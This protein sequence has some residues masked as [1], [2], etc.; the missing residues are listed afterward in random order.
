MSRYLALMINPLR[1]IRLALAV[2]MS[3]GCVAAMNTSRAAQWYTEPSLTLSAGRDDNFLRTANGDVGQNIYSATARLTAGS[4]TENSNVRASAYATPYNYPGRD[5][6][7]N[8][9]AGANATLSHDY[10]RFGLNLDGGIARSVLLAYENV[11]VDASRFVDDTT[12]RA[13]SATPTLR[14]SITPTFELRAAASHS[15]VEYS[16]S[17]ASLY[18]DYRINAPSLTATYLFNETTQFSVVVSDSLTEY[19]NTAFPATSET[20]SGRIGVNTQ[21]SERFDLNVSVGLRRTTS[22]TTQLQPVCAVFVGSVCIVFVNQPVENTVLN[23]GSTYNASLTWQ[24]VNGSITGR[25]SQEVVP[26]GQAASLLG[27][28][29]G[30]TITHGISPY[31]SAQLSVTSSRYRADANTA[32]LNSNVNYDF[33][34]VE[35]AL[36]WRVSETWTSRLTYGRTRYD[37]VTSADKTIDNS[38]YLTLSWNPLRRY[39]SF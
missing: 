23:E 13:V 4:Q 17:R 24:Y 26:S 20:Q 35:P 21:M 10:E 31:L 6:L 34:R 30:G 15:D 9:G 16:G 8:T 39:V 11:D 22:E 12:T 28:I 37:Y 36:S 2:A 14:W 5:E 7:D 19:T 3:V 27:T 32:V 18:S 38:V 25:A 29:F 33:Y 1:R